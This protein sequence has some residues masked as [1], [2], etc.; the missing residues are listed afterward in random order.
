MMES[1]EHLPHVAP[2]LNIN[3]DEANRYAGLT[4]DS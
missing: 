4:A 1:T 3:S 2:W